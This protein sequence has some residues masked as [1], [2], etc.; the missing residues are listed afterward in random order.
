MPIRKAEFPEF[1]EFPDPLPPPTPKPGGA[2]ETPPPPP[3]ESISPPKPPDK[4]AT[5]PPPPSLPE[6]DPSK[7]PGGAYPEI[8]QAVETA[9]N[10]L[11]ALYAAVEGRWLVAAFEGA[12]CAMGVFES[13]PTYTPPTAEERNRAEGLGTTY[14]SHI[15]F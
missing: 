12:A 1:P 10:C 5:I 8:K 15:G 6:E 7:K 13:L 14:P 11:G 2:S 4:V 3:P 9:S